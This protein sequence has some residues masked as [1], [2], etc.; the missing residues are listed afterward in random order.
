MIDVNLL[1]PP[2]TQQGATGF[3]NDEALTDLEVGALIEVMAAGDPYLG[4]IA[5]HYFVN[6]PV[7]PAVIRWRQAVVRDALEHPDLIRD[8]EAIARHGAALERRSAYALKPQPPIS[9]LLRSRELLSLL[10]ADLRSLAQR[11]AEPDATVTSK[12]LKLLLDAIST[13]FTPEY[14]DRLDITLQELRFEHGLMARATLAA[15]NLTSHQLLLEGPFE[16]RGWRDRLRLAR[17]DRNRIE[18]APRDQAGSETLRELRNQ[19]LVDISGTTARGLGV[20]IDFFVRLGRELAWLVGALN[21]HYRLQSLDLPLC[22]PEPTVNEGRLTFSTLVEPTLSLRTGQRPV[23]NDLDASTRSNI[24]ISGANSG[25]KTTWLQSVALATLM[26][27]AGLFVCAD[28]FSADVRTTLSTFFPRDEDRELE[29]GRLD[30]E[31]LRLSQTMNALSEGALL[32]LNEP[33]SS[34]NEVEACAIATALVDD[35]RR[36]HIT[37]IVVTHY[38][39]LA[40]SLASDGTSLRPAV[41]D[42]GQRTYRIELAAPPA[43]SSAMDIYERLGGW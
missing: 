8:L 38:P 43:D 4:A 34:T 7:D 33:L 14:L 9:A 42:N 2:D 30:D 27:Q 12:G 29:R 20:V 39:T 10:I 41:V 35:L 22:F 19:A 31:L 6:A 15:G 11:V 1:T 13:N 26:M 18:I 36:R 24:V 40:R 5:Q 28:A 23:A 32:L 16:G 37:T 3:T 17:G 25:G 21:L